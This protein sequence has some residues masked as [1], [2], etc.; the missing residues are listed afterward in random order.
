MRGGNLSPARTLSIRASGSSDTVDV[1]IVPPRRHRLGTPHRPYSDQGTYPP[2]WNLKGCRSYGS[3]SGMGPDL[4]VGSGPG[5]NRRE[6]TRLGGGRPRDSVTAPGGRRTME[7]VCASN[8]TA[9]RTLAAAAR[10]FCS[11]ARE[12][13]GHR[14]FPPPRGPL[15]E[16]DRSC[17]DDPG[18]H[19]DASAAMEGTQ[20]PD[21]GVTSG[22]RVPPFGPRKPGGIQPRARLPPQRRSRRPTPAGWPQLPPI[23]RC[24]SSFLL[25]ESAA[26]CGRCGSPATSK[27]TS[28]SFATSSWGHRPW[29]CSPSTRPCP[30]L[31]SRFRSIR[32]TQ[33]LGGSASTAR[34]SAST[35]A[36]WPSAA[37]ASAATWLPRSR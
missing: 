9:H 35:A 24:A 15:T 7:P 18:R 29:R 6:R 33:P 1:R 14:S 8:A 2:S 5:C 34:R 28:G 25:S 16:V 3:F 12:R 4:T 27:T 13:G 19:H 26:L 17:Q 32:P 10:T 36:S 37:T 22:P 31:G 30:R 11:S 20:S 23:G 21:A